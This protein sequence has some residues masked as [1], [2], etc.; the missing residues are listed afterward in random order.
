VSGELIVW[1]NYEIK[2][3][4]HLFKTSIIGIAVLPKPIEQKVVQAAKIRPLHKYEQGKEQE[5]LEIVAG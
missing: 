4:L 2:K 3:S 5:P 1:N